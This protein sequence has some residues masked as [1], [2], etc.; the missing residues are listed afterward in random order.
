[1]WSSRLIG[2]GDDSHRKPIGTL[3][4][5][6]EGD[7]PEGASGP[8]PHPLDRVWFHPT[9]LSAYMSATASPARPPYVVR[10]WRRPGGG[11]R[12]DVR[13]PVHHRC[14]Q[15]WHHGPLPLRGRDRRPRR[16]RPA[17][18]LRAGRDRGPEPGHGGPGAAGWRHGPDRDRYLGGEGPGPH[19]RA[20]AA[21]DRWHEPRDRQPRQQ[22]DHRADPGRR[23]RDRSRPAP[24]RRLRRA[25][26]PLGR[27]RGR[28]RG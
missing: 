6:P 1:M 27:A 28:P 21:G 4:G 22:G 19:D 25:R 24:G 13:H 14:A 15:Q 3:R 8:P 5:M 10:R 2:R 23:P 20:S 17:Q 9:E 26:P 16:G 11:R 12:P 7:D 18:H